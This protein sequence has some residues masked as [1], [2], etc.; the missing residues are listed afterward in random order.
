MVHQLAPARSHFSEMPQ[1]QDAKCSRFRCNYCNKVMADNTTRFTSHLATCE[2]A[3]S[4]L[5]ERMR[6]LARDKLSPL[7][8][9][10]AMGRAAASALS[11]S[12]GSSSKSGTPPPSTRTGAPIVFTEES[13]RLA[14]LLGLALLSLN[15][16]FNAVDNEH[17]RNLIH[18]LR[19]SFELPPPEELLRIVVDQ[20]YAAATA[21]ASLATPPHP[22]TAH[23]ISLLS[24]N[25]YP[26]AAATT[27]SQQAPSQDAHSPSPGAPPALNAAAASIGF[28]PVVVPNIA[29]SLSVASP[30]KKES[31]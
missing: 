19:P 25:V 30:S 7:V 20:V 24:A 10:E 22:S 13:L 17:F 1:S 4:D 2:T 11:A 18:A 26:Q 31:M 21:P 14:R 15:M 27:S 16:P 23:I 29:G 28:P 8:K 5:R 12:F 9:P 3:P 6:S